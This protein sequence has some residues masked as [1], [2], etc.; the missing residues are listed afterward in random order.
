MLTCSCRIKWSNRSSGPSNSPSRIF[1]SSV[2]SS[3]TIC[4]IAPA[5]LSGVAASSRVSN[6][7]SGLSSFILI[8][9][10]GSGDAGPIKNLLQR[11][12]SDLPRLFAT[13]AQ[14]F[15][16]LLVRNLSY[17]LLNRPQKLHRHF[18]Q[19]PLQLRVTLIGKMLFNFSLALTS[20][21][22]IDLEQVINCRSRLV[23]PDLGAGIRHGA[24]EL[25]L[26]R[27]SVVHQHDAAVWIVVRL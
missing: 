24:F 17:S 21:Q 15:V 18:R 11:R 27:V 26:D 3:E 9:I 19:L 25:A 20:D 14:H 23:E 13:L 1:R 7:V 8:T 22:M 4:G 5:T 16:E 12:T 2:T 10:G 6:L